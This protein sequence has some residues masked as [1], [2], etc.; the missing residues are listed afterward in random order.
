MTA[1]G[2]W[3]GVWGQ[4]EKEEGREGDCSPS[5]HPRAA[6]PLLLWGI[7]VWRRGP[8]TEG[9]ADGGSTEAGLRGSDHF[10]R[11]CP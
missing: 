1:Q 5:Q 6:G 2:R 4:L 7:P 10:G 3:A 11:I 8:G 9:Q